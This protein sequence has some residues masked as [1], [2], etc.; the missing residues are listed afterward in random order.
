[1]E[2]CPYNIPM[3]FSRNHTQA[4]ATRMRFSVALAMRSALK[5]FLTLADIAGE[6]TV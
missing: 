1:M 4:H 6:Y 5:R 2:L 3:K